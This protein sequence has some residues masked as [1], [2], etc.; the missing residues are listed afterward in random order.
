MRAIQGS[1]VVPSNRGGCILWISKEGGPG[2]ETVQAD[3][4]RLLASITLKAPGEPSLARMRQV[5][6][7]NEGEREKGKRHSGVVCGVTQYG[8]V[9]KVQIAGQNPYSGTRLIYSEEF[10]RVGSGGIGRS[11]GVHKVGERQC[12]CGIF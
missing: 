1:G 8:L 10:E 4:V 11:G 7:T 12:Q 3:S 5:H 6:K 9:A 2:R